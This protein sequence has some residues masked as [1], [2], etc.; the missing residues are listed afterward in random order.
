[1]LAIP[2]LLWALWPLTGGRDGPAGAAEDDERLAL[3]AEKRA[4]LEA[5]RELDLDRQAGHVDAADFAAL[6]AGYESRAAAVL[7]RLDALEASRS[8]GAAAPVGPVPLAPRPWTQQPAVLG[9]SGLALLAFGVVL[10]LL[11]SR[12]SA[13]TP[14]ESPA[15]PGPAASAAPPGPAGT[16][17]P[18][19]DDTGTGPAPPLSPEMLE[20]MLRAAHASLDAGRYQEAIAAYKAVLRRDPR[21]VEAITHMGVILAAAG[22]AEGALEAFDRALAI[23][24]TYAHALWDK[25]NLLHDVRGDFAAAAA[26]WERF[27]AVAPPGPDRERAA[28]RL[29]DARSR[30]A[31]SGPPAPGATPPA[32]PRSS[33]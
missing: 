19:A 15:A 1:V 14:P 20:G 31:A 12:H 30:R 2:A 24:P 26:T 6:R 16:G 23:D 33:P 7:R 5:L 8:R 17:S 25:A 3:G 11:V 22:H 9:A 13:P 18:V 29:R 28:E 27:L 4:A 10:G 32:R 21:N